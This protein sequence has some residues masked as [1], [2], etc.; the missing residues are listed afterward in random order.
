MK[1]RFDFGTVDITSVT[2]SDN[3]HFHLF[4]LTHKWEKPI[5]FKCIL[6]PL[7]VEES[8]F[9][10]VQTESEICESGLSWVELSGMKILQL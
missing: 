6:W 10:H 5:Y 2:G 9:P 1:F 8:E 4:A 3:Y 7:T